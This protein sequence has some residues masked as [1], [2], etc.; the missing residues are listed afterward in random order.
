LSENKNSKLKE[1]QT[2][3]AAQTA[4]PNP[5]HGVSDKY[6]GGFLGLFGRPGLTT[7]INPERKT[8]INGE[9]AKAHGDFRRPGL[10]NLDNTSY[11]W[12]IYRNNQW[13]SISGQ[14]KKDLDYTLTDVGDYYFQ[15]VVRNKP[16]LGSAKTYGSNVF[17]VSVV[18]QQ[19]QANKIT[20]TNNPNILVND[21]YWGL[22]Y[23]TN[24]KNAIGTVKWSVNDN[25]LATINQSGVITTNSNNLKGTV[26]V[27]AVLTNSDGSTVE[28]S[29]SIKVGD[30][31]S[32][33]TVEVGED[34]T[35]TIS[36]SLIPDNN[37]QKVTYQWYRWNE[38]KRQELISTN[39]DLIINNVG[40][41]LNSSQYQVLVNIGGKVQES[42]VATLTV[43]TA[44]SE[45]LSESESLS[46]SESLSESE[47]L[48]TSESLS[49]S[50]SLSTSES[51]SESESLSTSESLSESESLS[52]SE[53]L[54]ESESLST[55]E[56][57][58]ESESLSTSESL[59]E[60]ESLSTS[61]SLSESESL[62]T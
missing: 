23:E 11:Q 44:A 29:I 57:L 17:A 54:S 48:S 41:N 16:L 25:S 12:Y 40:V 26:I 9:K 56:S 52:T 27:K 35:F 1:R 49:E 20:V 7:D 28:N 62:S 55:S 4:P 15:L 61:E 46:T 2:I 58:S 33:Q 59:S 21:S 51:L 43:S 30:I 38:G 22:G 39:K 50:E 24:P 5:Y 45:S 37:E 32:D 6:Y 13:T 60:S 14:T 10:V 53:S 42:N 31:I 47:S 19:V 3:K 34:A 8:I 36:P 18:Q